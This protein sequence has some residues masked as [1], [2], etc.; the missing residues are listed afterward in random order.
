MA[1][2]NA[3]VRVL[4]ALIAVS[5]G[6]LA[7]KGVD[8]YQAV[9]QA[10]SG[11]PAAGPHPETAL[12]AGVGDRPSEEAGAPDGKEDA[13]PGATARADQCLPSVDYAA[14]TGMSSQEVLVLRSLQQRRQQL[15]EREAGISTREAAATAAEQ[16]LQD[17]IADLK[18]VETEVQGLLA[19]MTA[20]GDKRMADL[21]K[22]YES[23]KP[24]DA[25]KIFDGMEDK[26]LI[27]IAKTMKPA[28]LAAVMSLMQPKRA[29]TLTRM[30]SE[31]AKPPTSIDNLP[32]LAA[33]TPT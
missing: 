31:L 18:K 3:G 8:I 23:M 5:I 28:S 24:K 2:I 12:T 25:A 10:A 17:Q 11:E 15:D 27:D 9:A 26:L 20:Q 14:E 19:S 29:E 21:V 30:L 22:T 16:R 6:A 13:P 1:K 33:Q 4:P 7:F 32:Q